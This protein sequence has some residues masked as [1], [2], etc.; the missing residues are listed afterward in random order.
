MHRTVLLSVAAC[1]LGAAPASA[2][3]PPPASPVFRA[4]PQAPPV[5]A[6]SRPTSVVVR[7]DYSRAGTAE[8]CPDERELRNVV[9]ARMGYDPFAQP[10][11]FAPPLLRVRV[12]RGGGGFVASFQLLDP[13]GKVLWS[14]PPLADPDCAHLVHVIGEVTIPVAIDVAASAATLP[15]APLPPAPVPPP[16]LPPP[17]APTVDRAAPPRGSAG[18]TVRLGARGGVAIGVGPAVTA[19]LSADVGVGWEHFSINLEG[20]ADV[21]AAGDVDMGVRLR[22]S[23]L[24]GSL[25]PCGH[26][27]WFV[28]CGLLSLGVLR[29]EGVNVLHPAE[30]S[31][32]YAAA[33]VRAGLEWPV[34]PAF[35]LRVSGDVLVNLHPAAAQVELQP[36]LMEVWRSGPFA[37]VVG[38]GVLA[39]FGGR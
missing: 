36:G 11:G 38:A 2:Q 7:V 6:P 29:A 27:R 10:G 14:R 4:A 20:R 37:G 17:L 8:A 31:T 34:V 16:A 13:A 18:P 30:D 22:T 33:G 5:P 25:V 23:V 1:L 21:P 19:A 24:S 3:Q 12:E 39:R 28:G 15:T 26:Y 9:A 35:A 32:F